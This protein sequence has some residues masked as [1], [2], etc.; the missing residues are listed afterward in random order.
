MDFTKIPLFQR[1]TDR[2]GWLNARQDV[3]SQNVANADTPGF[4]PRDLKPQSFEEHVKRL[5][6]V[7]P[8]LTSPMHMQGTV[9]V[10]KGPGSDKEKDP[11]ESAPAGNSVVLEE[12]MMH[13]TETQTNY[14]LITNLYRKHVD[15]MKRAI[16]TS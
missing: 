1:M 3:L 8:E 12:Q 14:Q 7:N 4:I 9:P 5:E 11:Y 6:P 13:V 10:K 16:G 15:M 2:L